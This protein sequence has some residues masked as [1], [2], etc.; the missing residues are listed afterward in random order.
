[1]PINHRKVFYLVSKTKPVRFISGPY[2]ARQEA[3][4]QIASVQKKLVS[5]GV[6]V[7]IE[8]YETSDAARPQT[9]L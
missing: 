8:V 6:E 4:S 7:D 9:V 5:G 1:M 2:H 3:R